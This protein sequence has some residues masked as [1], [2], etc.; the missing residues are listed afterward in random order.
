VRRVLVPLRV[1]VLTMFGQIAIR[2]AAEAWEHEGAMRLRRDVFCEEQ[3]LFAQDDRDA[4]DEVAQTIVA[5]TLVI[6]IAD[7]VVGTVRIHETAPRR[8]I[9]SRL[10][11]RAEY[12]GVHGL[13]AGLVRRA[14]GTALGLGCDAFLATVQHQNVPFFRRLRWEALEK[15]EI[16]G[17]PHV[18]M[19]AT[20]AAYEPWVEH[21]SDAAATVRLA[22]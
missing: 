16:N 13:G 8:W 2:A 21:A 4:H 9:G 14:V 15:R 17:Y 18:L 12:R 1:R 20:L 7:A 22:S 3:G 10:A 19:R 6:G 11:I 5:V